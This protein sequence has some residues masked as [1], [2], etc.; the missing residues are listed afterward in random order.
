MTLI[1]TAIA[2][3]PD[4]PPGS[5]WLEIIRLIKDVGF[6]ITVA[7]Y[8]LWKI[9]PALNDLTVAIHEMKGYLERIHD[10]IP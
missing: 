4:P 2:A 3:S 5:S 10:R 8:M 7:A 1:G 9:V 6:P